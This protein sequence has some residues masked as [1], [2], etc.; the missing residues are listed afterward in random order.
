[1]PSVGGFRQTYNGRNNPLGVGKTMTQKQKL[2]MGWALAGIGIAAV[3]ALA[4]SAYLS[5][6][7]VLRLADLNLCF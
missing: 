5:P 2:A 4:Y 3:L 7:M 1:M 6:A